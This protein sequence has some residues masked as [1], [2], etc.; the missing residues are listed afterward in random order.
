MVL[1]IVCWKNR[2]NLIGAI[3]QGGAHRVDDDRDHEAAA[4]TAADDDDDD[5]EKE[6]PWVRK[7]SFIQELSESSVLLEEI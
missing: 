5:D 1:G 6:D 3:F 4:A 2:S 7:K